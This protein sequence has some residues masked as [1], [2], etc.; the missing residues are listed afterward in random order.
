M[1]FFAQT[2]VAEF[3]R[4]KGDSQYCSGNKRSEQ[5][6]IENPTVSTAGVQLSNL[7]TDN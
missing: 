2:V 4:K 6:N 3:K 1:E 5:L 7:L